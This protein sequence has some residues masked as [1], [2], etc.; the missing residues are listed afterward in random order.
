MHDRWDDTY[1]SVLIQELLSRTPFAG[2]LSLS[3]EELMD[4]RTGAWYFA[5]REPRNISI[6]INNSQT[7]Q[8]KEELRKK[9]EELNSQ[10]FSPGIVYETEETVTLWDIL[11]QHY[12]NDYIIAVVI[13]LSGW[14]GGFLLLAAIALFYLLLF[15]CIL[16][17]RGNLASC[18]AFACGQILLWQTIFYTLGNFDFQYC[19]FPNLPLL[20]E[21]RI[22]MVFNMVLVGFILSAYRYDLV[23]AEPAECT[24]TVSL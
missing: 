21:G 9:Y 18:T 20:S 7:P 5:S 22:S 3:P 11:P 12:Y 6:A 15:R 10:G 17:I 8:E 1:N 23:T 16:K 13:F 24:S 4:Y 19:A 2:G 14:I